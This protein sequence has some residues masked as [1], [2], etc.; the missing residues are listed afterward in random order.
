M[1][2]RLVAYSSLGMDKLLVIHNDRESV[3]QS[4]DGNHSSPGSPNERQKSIF[5]NQKVA[6]TTY[7]SKV[8]PRVQSPV[9]KQRG[10]KL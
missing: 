6:D 9:R 7:R 5:F 1:D 2:N 8:S 3:K 10:N 4:N